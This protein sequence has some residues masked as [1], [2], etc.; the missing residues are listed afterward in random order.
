MSSTH[1]QDTR[2]LAVNPPLGAAA[3]FAVLASSTVTNTGGTNV[4]GDVGVSPGAAIVG[5][6]PGIITGTM[7]AANATSLSAQN[8]ITTAYN[9]LAVQPCDQ[10]LTGQNLGGLTLTPGVYCFNTSAQLTGTLTLNGLGNPGSVWVFQ[11]GSTLTTASGANVNF[12]NGGQACG[13]H[14]QIGSSATIGSGTS[15][16]GNIFAQASIT[17]N[18]GANNQGSLYAR[19]AAVTLDTNAVAVVGSCGF[20]P[21]PPPPTPLPT[22][23]PPGPPGP[24]PPV[25]SLPDLAA[26]AL[27]ALLLVTGTVLLGRR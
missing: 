19:T 24:V 25:P 6:P 1:A 20:G 16:R 5:F 2:A 18:T 9:M 7:H 10:N 3:P 14:W 11:T 23:V 12:T 13:V 8:S 15:F 27:F 26:G 17:M 4:T 22:P 21:P